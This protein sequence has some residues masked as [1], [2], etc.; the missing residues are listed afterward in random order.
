M[1]YWF[2]SLLKVIRLSLVVYIHVEWSHIRI[3][4]LKSIRLFFQDLV[5]RSITNASKINVTDYGEDT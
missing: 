1:I 4:P 2:Y 3:K 5:A